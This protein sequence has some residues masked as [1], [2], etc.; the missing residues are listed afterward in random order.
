MLKR[1][2]NQLL[3]NEPLGEP[4]PG[5]AAERALAVLL[6]RVARADRDYDQQERGRI[7][8]ILERRNGLS[9]AEAEAMLAEA[10]EAESELTDTV[11]FTRDI[12]QGIP[13]EERIDLMQELWSLALTDTQRDPGEDQL[14][15][16]TAGLLGVS[17]QDSARA[18]LRA[19]GDLG[20]G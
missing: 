4:L 3:G 11:H 19:A 15:R 16:L 6:V 18:R 9:R 14:L 2:L 13:L 10:E 1:F 7:I 12:K 8:T 20:V 17:D 5:E